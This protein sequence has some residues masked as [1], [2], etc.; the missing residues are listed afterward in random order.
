M[1]SRASSRT[2]SIRQ[3]LRMSKTPKEIWELESCQAYRGPVSCAKHPDEH[4][5]LKLHKKQFKTPQWFRRAV[6]E[7]GNNYNGEYLS[8]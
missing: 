5:K 8:E 4:G 3:I 7:A 2:R 1:G 6:G